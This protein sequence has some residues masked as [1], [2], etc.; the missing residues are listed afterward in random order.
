MSSNPF[1]SLPSSAFRTIEMQPQ[2]V[3]FRQDHQTSGLFQVQSG[4]VTLQR[5]GLNGETLT[6]HRAA[7]GGFFAEASIFSKTYHCDAICSQAGR[8]VQI[9]KAQVTAM[10]QTDP[11]F[12]LGFS[13]LLAVQVQNN[14]GHIEIL[15]IRSAKDRVFAAFQAGYLQGTVPEFASRINLTQEACY[16][17]LRALCNDNAILQTGRGRYELGPPHS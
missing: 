2:D 5:A 12:A 11:V 8:V 13:R 16:R 7:S 17:A 1:S 15:G 10:I 14:R 3:L 9:A 4:S 6:L